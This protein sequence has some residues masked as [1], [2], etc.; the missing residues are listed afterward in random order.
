MPRKSRRATPPQ[1]NFDEGIPYIPPRVEE[2]LL[3]HHMADYH[4]TRLLCTSHGRGQLA[5][6]LASQNPEGIVECHYLDSHHAALARE[7]WEQADAPPR[8]LCQPDFPEEEYDAICIPV[9]KQGNA[10]LTRELL[11]Q[12]HQRLKL[13]G[14]LFAAVDHPRDHW[15]NEQFV[16]MFPKVTRLV[17]KQGVIYIGKKLGPLKKTRNFQADFSV[18][19]LGRQL[20]FMTRPGVFSH[21]HLDDGAWALIKSLP[22]KPK[23]SVL[24]LGCGCGAVG[25]AAMLSADRVQ[26]TAIDS[27]ARAVQCTQEN[28]RRNLTED[29]LRR[30]RVEMTHTAELTEHPA[31]DLVATNP[32][33]FSRFQ[34]AELFVESARRMLKR[35]GK[36]LIVTKMPFWY[37]ENLPHTFRHVELRTMGTYTIVEASA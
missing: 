13:R 34:I 21:R 33:Y 36:L 30:F 35:N 31:F 5:G 3:I 16:E 15:L 23:M 37:E 19:Y 22:I 27:H 32:P 28:A 6:Y 24:D 10:E 29:Q 2:Q 1:E 18:P 25:I 20:S 14:E 17:K 11:Q 9:V 26:V 8:V 7:Y 4:G 12:A